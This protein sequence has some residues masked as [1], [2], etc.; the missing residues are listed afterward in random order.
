MGPTL[1]NTRPA[2]A[3][4]EKGV[5]H[6]MYRFVRLCDVTWY[7]SSRTG[8][9][10]KDEKEIPRYHRIPSHFE[11]LPGPTVALPRD[12]GHGSRVVVACTHVLTRAATFKRRCPSNVDV[13][14][15]KQVN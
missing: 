14:I 11:E 8:Q 13:V 4:H 5:S 7:L 12:L 9:P 2:V 1:R 6:F 10:R 3:K 15:P